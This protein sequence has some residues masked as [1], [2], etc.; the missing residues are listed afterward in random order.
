MTFTSQKIF[1]IAYYFIAFYF[2][3]FILPHSR[4]SFQTLLMYNMFIHVKLTHIG[5]TFMLYFIY[6]ILYFGL[7]CYQSYLYISYISYYIFV[8][9]C[10]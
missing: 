5:I 2:S 6:F 9:L 8:L 10:Y 1:F 4:K 7:L 3:Y